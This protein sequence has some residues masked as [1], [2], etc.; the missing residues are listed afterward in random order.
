MTAPS[1]PLRPRDFADVLETAVVQ[2][3]S[4]YTSF[5]AQLHV[6]IESFQNWRNAKSSPPFNRVLE[7]ARSGKMPAA[8][9]LDLLQCLSAGR[10]VITPAQLDLRGIEDEPAYQATG[11]NRPAGGPDQA[12]GLRE[13]AVQANRGVCD[14]QH[15]MNDALA[16]GHVTADEARNIEAVAQKPMRLLMLSIQGIVSLVPAP[17]LRAFGRRH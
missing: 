11:A 3:D 5:A 13:L 7:I 4:N 8:M 9:H 10:F 12:E 14:V 1:S 2:S 15:A 17:L 16:D 6:P